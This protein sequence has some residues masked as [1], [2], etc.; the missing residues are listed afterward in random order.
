MQNQQN[1]NFNHGALEVLVA[2]DVLG[3]MID[4]LN[5]FLV[6]KSTVSCQE[7][8][9]IVERQTKFLQDEYNLIVQSLKT[10]QTPAKH[11][12]RYE[13]TGGH[14]FTYGLKLNS[15]PKKPMKSVSEVSEEWIAGRMLGALKAC[16]T[17][18]TV[19]AIEATNPVVRRVIADSIPNDLEMA[20]EV[21]IYMNKKGFYQIPQFQPEVMTQLTNEF[22]PTN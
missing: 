8:L 13:M 12:E 21:A 3:S 2:R 17:V 19:G 10:G 20:Y 18:K 11:T 1:A 16:A 4:T 6:L 15:Q 7:L 9:G 14:D 22:G 5:Q